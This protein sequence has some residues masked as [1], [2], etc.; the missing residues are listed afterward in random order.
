MAGADERELSL[1]W[2]GAIP[3]V[4]SRERPDSPTWR[5]FVIFTSPNMGEHSEEIRI[6]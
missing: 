3:A 5:S 4:V 6:G 1:G 2:I